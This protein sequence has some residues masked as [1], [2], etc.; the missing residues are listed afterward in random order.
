MPTPEAAGF[1]GFGDL[2]TIAAG[3]PSGVAGT[4]DPLRIARL[5]GGEPA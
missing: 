2:I 3:M 1:A 5:P 4:T